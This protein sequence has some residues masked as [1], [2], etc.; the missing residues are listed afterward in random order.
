[1][2]SK[3]LACRELLAVRRPCDIDNVR[4]TGTIEGAN[5][6]NNRILSKLYLRLILVKILA[7]GIK[8]TAKRF[9]EA[10]FTSSTHIMIKDIVPYYSLAEN[11][12]L[13]LC[14]HFPQIVTS[15]EILYVP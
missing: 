12:V 15:I 11:L 14:L 6:K 8:S 4:R 9:L 10:N 2:Q 1:M 3:S 5:Y 13:K 7:F